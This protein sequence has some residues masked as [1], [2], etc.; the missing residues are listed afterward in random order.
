MPVDGTQTS[1]PVTLARDLQTYTGALADGDSMLAVVGG[2][3]VCRVPFWSVKAG[4]VSWWPD[5]EPSDPYASGSDSSVA[6]GQDGFTWYFGGMWRKAPAYSPANWEDL[7]GSVRFLKV[8]S[9]MELS[10]SEISN[11]RTSIGLG[12]AAVGVP[13]L[14]SAGDTG[15]G[16]CPVL[17]S[18]ADGRAS[19]P[20]ARRNVY[21]A[22]L[23]DNDDPGSEAHSAASVQYT[24]ALVAALDIQPAPTVATHSKPG[25]VLADSPE[26]DPETGYKGP[27]QVDSVGNVTIHRAQ[28]INGERDPNA[29]LVLLSS[30]DIPD[31]D[32][33]PDP[34]LSPDIAASVEKVS[35]MVARAVSAQAA[36]PAGEA[37]LGSVM[38]PGDGCLRL[39][40][41]TTPSGDIPPQWGAGAV[42]VN[43]A[44]TYKHGAVA[45]SSS[46]A[47]DASSS[48]EVN[49]LRYPVVPTAVAVKAYVD[50][51]LSGKLSLDGSGKVP[52][53][54][55]PYATASSVGAV[56]AGEGLYVSSGLLSVKNAVPALSES[57][58]ADF[59]QKAGSVYVCASSSE[60]V[61]AGLKPVVPTVDKV[62]EL[63]DGTSSPAATGG[64]KPWPYVY[65]RAAADGTAPVPGVMWRL[66]GIDPNAVRIRVNATAFAGLSECA[67]LWKPGQAVQSFQ[68]A[69]EG[70]VWTDN[71]PAVVRGRTYMIKVA[72]VAKNVMLACVQY[73]YVNP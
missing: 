43:P 38:V 35:K 56:Q 59:N 23:L 64:F 46:S 19:V 37:T 55:L 29:G 7:D 13:G 9:P 20:E 67:L 66:Y 27:F 4:L 28:C 21:G 10:A 47:L 26:P 24:K 48:I 62:K 17:V 8:D 69:S 31:D 49:G 53:G 54:N 22:L 36:V 11:A 61:V 15:S 3:A 33:T 73:S 40:K 45:V 14:V 12:N 71:T 70:L 5:G 60:S 72:N 2:T 39:V 51:G 34:D 58:S 41:A 1:F 63:I 6:A 65:V 42:D 44:E 50:N 57:Y 30:P 68:S 16:P 18:A 52:A 32:S 25:L